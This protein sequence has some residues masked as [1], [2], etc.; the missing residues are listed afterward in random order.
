MIITVFLPFFRTHWRYFSSLW[1]ATLAKEALPSP[2][3]WHTR[4]RICY[5]LSFH[6]VLGMIP[7]WFRRQSESGYSGAPGSFESGKCFCARCALAAFMITPLWSNQR[8]KVWFRT[9]VV[10]DQ[11][12]MNLLYWKSQRWYMV[13]AR[14]GNEQADHLSLDGTT[15][16]ANRILGGLVVFIKLPLVSRQA[17]FQ[18]KQFIRESGSG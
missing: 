13:S 4:P 11:V 8:W 6:I 5:Q 2:N 10:I 16:T 15:K 3:Q 12:C 18:V 1:R 7:Q 9:K 17:L 14:C